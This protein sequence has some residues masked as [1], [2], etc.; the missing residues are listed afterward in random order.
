MFDLEF[1]PNFSG[2]PQKFS[3]QCSS[4]VGVKA[5]AFQDNTLLEGDADA[6][7][8]IC[9]VIHRRNDTVPPAFTPRD[10]LQVSIKADTVS[11]ILAL[12]PPPI[13]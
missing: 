10:V 9:C 6:L 4:L 1:I 12:A 11:T 3:A 2:V 5:K 7:R 13:R 8:T